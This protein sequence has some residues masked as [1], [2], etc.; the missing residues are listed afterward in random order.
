[1]L[2]TG[3][4]K[5]TVAI[6]MNSPMSNYDKFVIQTQIENKSRVHIE[7]KKASIKKIEIQND[8]HDSADTTDYQISP[9]QRKV[10][11]INLKL[12]TK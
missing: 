1:M 8:R 3:T 6:K 7:P 5:K 11:K 2:E 12:K 4:S 10:N 9:I